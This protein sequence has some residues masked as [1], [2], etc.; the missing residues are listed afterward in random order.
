MP[1]GV[2]ILAC[3]LLPLLFLTFARSLF[4]LVQVRGWSMYPTFCNGDRVLALR[5]W[6]ARWLRRGQI[7]VW[8][9]PSDWPGSLVPEPMRG[10]FLIK[11]ITG[12]PGDTIVTPRLEPASSNIASTDPRGH[13]KAQVWHV[14]RNHYFVQGESP[15]LDSA[16][17]GPIPI[18]AIRGLA[19]L[20]LK[21]GATHGV[22]APEYLRTL[23]D[24][25]P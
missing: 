13:K 17:I 23:T 19:L 22:P 11:R 14:P 9:L 15:G 12:L 20:R 24:M 16:L 10:S 18:H 25:E 4:F 2:I 8:L 5:R 6:P 7:V 3:T 1:S 21:S